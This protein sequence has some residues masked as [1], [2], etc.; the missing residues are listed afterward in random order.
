ME[1]STA[2]FEPAVPGK[3]KPKALVKPR[4]HQDDDNRSRV[5]ESLSIHEARTDDP[6]FPVRF[7]GTSEFDLLF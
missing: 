3:P 4:R 6:F 5:V 2:T 7:P 1:N